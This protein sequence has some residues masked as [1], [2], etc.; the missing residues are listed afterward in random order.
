[1]PVFGGPAGTSDVVFTF[2]DAGRYDGIDVPL[3]VVD[4]ALLTGGG[5]YAITETTPGGGATNPGGLTDIYAVRFGLDGFHG[6]AVPGQLIQTWMPDFTTAG[7]VKKGEVEMGPVAVVLKAS[8][9]A[10]VLRNVKV[11]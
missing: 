10:A 6:V 2:A 9:A 3:M 4:G 5:A 7:A 8:K 1:M 11:A